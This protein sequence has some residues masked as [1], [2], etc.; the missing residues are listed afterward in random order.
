MAEELARKFRLNYVFGVEF[1]EL[2]QGS[3]D[4]PA[5]HGQ[6]LLCALPIRSSYILRFAN[7]SDFWKPRWYLPNWQTL[8]RRLGGRMALV[9]E[10]EAGGATLVIYNVHLERRDSESLRLL[11]LEEIVADAK[12]YQP[13][14]P[15]ILAGDFNTSSHDSPV[16]K[17]LGEAG[18]RNALE[19]ETEATNLKGASLDWI[20][21]RGPILGGETL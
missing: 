2:S 6:A 18:F 20:F 9:V 19:R 11:Q 8:Q 1:Q 7:Q 12:R 3:R 17:R 13:G 10:I 4:A 15:L 16:I 14:T 5:Y 21:V